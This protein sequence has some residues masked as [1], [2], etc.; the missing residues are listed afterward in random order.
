MMKAL[1]LSVCIGF[2]LLG[3]P[4]IAPSGE[5][6]GTPRGDDINGYN[7]LQSFETGYRFHTVGGN[8]GKYRSDVNFGNGIRLLGS[9]LTVNSREGHG[10]YF[11]ELLLNTQGLGNDPYEA[12]SLRV[13]KNKLYSYDLL[14]RL[15]DYYNPALPVAYGLHFQDTRRTMQD[16]NLVLLPTSPFRVFAGYS[17]VSQSGGGLSTVNQLGTF[18]DEFAPFANIRRLQ[19]E[20]RLGFELNVFGLKFSVLHGWEDFRDDT[21][22]ESGPS[23]GMNLDDETSISQFRRDQP[24]HGSTGNWRGNLLYDRLKFLA[25]NGRF[26]YAATRRNF[27]FDEASVG[28]NR[29]GAAF[30]RQ[31]LVS[32]N[33]TR[34][35]MTGALTLSLFPAGAVTVVNHTAFHHTRMNGDGAYSELDNSTLS[36]ATQEFSYLGIQTIT[37]STDISVRPARAIGL[38]GGYQFSERRIRSV[39]QQTFENIADGVTAE[40]YNRLHTGRFGVRL[41]PVKA[42]SVIL[43]AEIGRA[44]RPVFPT[45][46]RNYHALGGRIQYKTRNLLLAGYSRANYNFNSVSLFSHS[47]RSRTYGA[48]ASWTALPWMSFDANFSKLHLDT[49]TGIAY[50]Y[51]RQLIDDNSTYISNLYT[52]NA[53]VRFSIGSRANLFV[54]YTRVQDTGDGRAA[55]YA[56]PWV[57][58]VPPTD[59]GPGNFGYQTYPLTFESPFARFSLRL[60]SKI[61]WN[62]GYQYYRYDEELLSIQNYRAHTGFTSISWS[63]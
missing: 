27:I 8:E 63:F 40:Q 59:I 52:G 2:S 60:H 44:D 19:N 15:N 53:G 24:Y 10:K 28:V 61:R 21:R 58:G 41:Q 35:V 45:S 16:H 11:D 22:Y 38:F 7:V 31:I 48:D 55:L 47:S 62:A 46:E 25:I 3:Q 37:N 50:F 39:E 17:R 30:N 57:P 9:S 18:G 49:L 51:D 29:F 5:P 32:G 14:W 1:L 33:G 4:V 6:V 34:P 36:L 26:T 42:L 54:G 23:Q 20:Y 56:A 13:K 43:D 12:A